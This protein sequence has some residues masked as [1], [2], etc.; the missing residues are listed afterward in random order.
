MSD[1]LW[2]A[3][4]DQDLLLCPFCGGTASFKQTHR[5][6]LELTCDGCGVKFVQRW[7]R[8]SRTWLADKMAKNWNTRTCTNA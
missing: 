1:D 2:T 5:D 8:F 7:R 3:S 4:Q 6:R